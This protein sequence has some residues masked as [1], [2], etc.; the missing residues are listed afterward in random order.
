M[1]RDWFTQNDPAEPVD[2][3]GPYTAKQYDAIVV[4]AGPAGATAACFMA[5]EG[6]DVLLLDRAAYPGA[7]N[8]GGANVIV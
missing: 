7:K 8:C 1:I 5:R 4:G 6:L 2:K 3:A